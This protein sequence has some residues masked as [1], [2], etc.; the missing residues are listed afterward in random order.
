MKRTLVILSALV[1][2][3]LPSSAKEDSNGL[4]RD[5]TVYMVEHAHT[6]IG[7][8]KPQFEIMSEHLRY[9]DYVLDYCDL[10]KD[11]PLE[12]R[13]KWT[14]ETTWA[15]SEYIK[16]R[17]ESQV[18]RLLDCIKRGQVEVTAMFFNM[19]ETADDNSLRYFLQPV[20]ELKEM[21]IP[22]VTAMQNDVNG[23]AWCF[24]EWLS[25]L[26][27]KY[28]TMGI[29]VH[30]SLLPFENPTVFRWESPSGDSLVGFEG[31]IY[32]Q[33]NWW[34]V[35]VNDQNKL[36][37]G[38]I[39]FLRKLEHDG[40]PFNAVVVQYS[41][42][43]TDNSP[44]S[45]K[46]CHTVRD[47]NANHDNPKLRTALAHEFLE[48]A[49]E[50]YPDSIKSYRMAW[51]DWWTDGFGSAAKETSIARKTHADAVSVEGL[52]SMAMAKGLKLPE[53]VGEQI[54]SVN[55]DL[56]FWDE[57]TF[58]AA[59]SINDPT[60]WNSQIQWDGK[61]SYAWTAQRSAK[62]LYE[63]AAGLLQE[64]IHKDDVP[65]VTL[66]NSL[67]WERDAFT[68]LYLDY[69][70]IPF[71]SIFRIEDENG[72]RVSV[73]PLNWRNEGRYYR[74]FARN[75]PALGYKTYK[76][77]VEDRDNHETA[78]ERIATNIIENDWYRLTV[79]PVKGTLTSL[80]DKTADREL[81]DS[82]AEWG[83]GTMIYE[84]LDDRWPLARANAVGLHRT[85]MHDVTV[86]EVIREPLCDK[87]IVRAQCDGLTFHGLW[88]EIKLFRDLP[89]IEMLYCCRRLDE[90]DPSSIYVAF[91]FAGGEAADV[92]FDVQGGSVNPRVN[93]LPGS[94]TAW[95]TVQNYI[96]IRPEEGYQVLLGS[97][98][99]PLY[100]I[101]DML[102]GPFKRV[103]DYKHPHIYSWI[104][105][106]YWVTNFLASQRG[107]FTWTYTITS[108]K[109]DSD[110]D[111]LRTSIGDRVPFYGRGVP[112]GRK[113]NKA[114]EWSA[115]HLENNDLV[116]I[117]T[118]PARRKGY[119]VMEI[120][121]T[122]GKPQTLSIFDGRNHRKR[123]NVVNAVEEKKTLRRKEVTVK[124]YSNTFILVRM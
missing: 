39:P 74:I 72:E 66:F 99:V 84:K 104:M 46:G 78:P 15:V 59:E 122:S 108:M 45:F 24:P 51:P 109:S 73:Q 29:N 50:N 60:I 22:I 94:S 16:V 85:A 71:G 32:I 42:Y 79:D 28:F 67:A 23:L 112:Q 47:W 88:M 83:F 36:E 86:S 30:K 116:T 61:S 70:I 124:P 63:T 37:E 93:Q 111:A 54:E 75:V 31:L 21:G 113:D 5:W 6:D 102:D 117:V 33:G 87:V 52:M 20:R 81:V 82:E 17:P 58:G 65:T 114:M 49:A 13:F 62:I 55:R 2:T 64:V 89:R 90:T 56:L 26:G 38:L 100:M 118:T 8:T 119:A 107:E 7:Y 1:L 77:I 96:A 110:A 27:V 14:C 101:G 80:Y 10:T 123:F 103:N 106:N 121:E 97:E 34:G 115:L 12:Y 44:P 25:D 4:T 9:I 76:V 95:N 69:D 48:Y 35:H 92:V 18:K 43:D 11:Y 120:R 3:V 57:H 19:A 68:T 98:E 91:P 41:G 40:Y 53:C 105:N